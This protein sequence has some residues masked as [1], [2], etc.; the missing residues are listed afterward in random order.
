MCMWGVVME[1]KPEDK[2]MFIWHAISQKCIKDYNVSF[3]KT[4]TQ[5]KQLEG[6]MR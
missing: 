2:I 5:T 1:Q 4:Q 6:K 3:E